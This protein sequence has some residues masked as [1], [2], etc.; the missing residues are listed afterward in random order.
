[1][2]SESTPQAGKHLDLD[3]L[4]DVLA[5]E[6]SQA[7]ADA[8]PRQHLQSC[9]TC[10]A[11][12]ASLRSA[13][14]AVAAD[15]GSLAAV[16]PVPD[17]LDAR[18]AAAVRRTAAVA[19]TTVLP[20]T[21]V[22]SRE[23]ARASRSRCLLAAGGLAAAAV[24][25]VGGGLLLAS[26]A[27]DTSSNA[28]A[29]KASPTSFPVSATGTDYRTNAALQAALP[30]LLKA[31]RTA[32][33]QGLATIPRPSGAAT[34]NGDEQAT[35]PLANLRSPKGLAACLASLTDPA[36][37]GMPLALDYASYKGKPALV[38]VLPSAKPSKLDVWVVGASCNQP[39]SDL[40][41]YF[42]ADRPAG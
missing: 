7:D 3:E 24:V 10:S 1:M 31:T 4:A 37:R 27:G 23:H 2:T 5:A 6:S 26:G 12:L 14:D 9:S 35:D 40:L 22:A 41:L 19:A 17:D 32:S 39:E 33:T 25:V 16:P 13:L 21:P 18:V 34:V 36:D 38:V 42:R 30:G 11:Q 28:T 8:R 20:A 15:L 29:S